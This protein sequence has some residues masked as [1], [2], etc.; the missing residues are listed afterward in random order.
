MAAASV[1]LAISVIL[2][3]VA[4]FLALRLV[5]LTERKMAWLLIAA[6]I[7]LMGMRRSITMFF[8]MSGNAAKPPDLATE[9]VALTI[10]TLMVFGVA[11]I[12]PLF[13]SSLRTAEVVREKE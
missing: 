8:L 4:A 11:R 7:V 13:R 5:R 2:Q 1:V 9:L 3:F 6:A 12:T 10:S